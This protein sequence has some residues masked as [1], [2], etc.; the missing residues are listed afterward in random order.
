MEFILNNIK[1]PKTKTR[2]NI[3]SKSIECFCLG[4]VNY[5]GQ[6]YL[7]KKT[8]G[9]SK[10]NFK[11]PDLLKNLTNL[12]TSHDPNFEWTTIQINKNIQS[13]PHI[14]KNNVGMSYIIGFGDY[15]GGDLVIEGIPHD[16][17]NKFLKFDGT[18]GH[19]VS[20]FIGTRYSI[21]FF[22]H[23]FKPP[24]QKFRNIRVKIDGLYNKT[25]LIKPYKN[26]L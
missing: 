21:I 15:T 20:D 3:S 22:T 25:K 16:I 19:W 11:Y 23:T 13:P 26:N 17:K 2:N 8:K 9:E 4:E 6:K 5:R 12:I 10:W 18:L 24:S 14:D 7:N 1:F